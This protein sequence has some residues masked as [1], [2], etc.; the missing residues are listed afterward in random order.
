MNSSMLF[1]NHTDL[2]ESLA[3]WFSYINSCND[4]STLKSWNTKNVI[5]LNSCFSN[6][7]DG[8]DEIDLNNWDTGKVT[9]IESIFMM[10]KFKG[11]KVDS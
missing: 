3:F 7:G 6:S 8:C 1:T 9:S 11:I 5:D 10:S 2:I 4:F